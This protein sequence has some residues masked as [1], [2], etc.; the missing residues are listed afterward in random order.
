LPLLKETFDQIINSFIKNQW[1]FCDQF[2]PPNLINSLRIHL[3]EDYNSKI[4][5]DASI[6]NQTNKIQNETIRNDKIKWLHRTNDIENEFLRV[7]DDFV[8]HLNFTCF[9]GITKHEFHFSHYKKGNF[10]KKH[11]DQFKEN[12]TRAFSMILYLNPDWQEADGGKLKLYID[13]EVL[14]IAP[15]ENTLIFFDSHT[16][17]HEVLETHVNRLSITGWLRRD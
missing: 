11:L 15:K 4:F 14:E 1:G 2:L 8:S 7:I 17:L 16:M 9:T 12:Q 3:L 5:F 10:Y 13:D 6:G